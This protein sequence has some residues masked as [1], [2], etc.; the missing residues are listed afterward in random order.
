MFNA[1]KYKSPPNC[2]RIIKK[3]NILS[4]SFQVFDFSF[5]TQDYRKNFYIWKFDNVEYL[6]KLLM[7]IEHML[8]FHAVKWMKGLSGYFNGMLWSAIPTISKLFLVT[9]FRGNYLWYRNF[10]WFIY[11][12]NMSFLCFKRY[13][14][15]IC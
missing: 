6:G 14:Y 4:L 3:I 13:N 12:L 1:S 11:I 2:N 15:C 8:I 5:S 10:Y 7:N 9:C